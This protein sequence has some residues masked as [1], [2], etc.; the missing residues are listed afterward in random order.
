MKTEGHPITIQQGQLQVPSDPIIPF[1]QGDGVGPDIWKASVRVIE[2]AV[3]KAYGGKRQIHW[4]ELYAGQKAFDRSGKWLPQETI[5]TIEQYLIAL[6][7]PLAIPMGGGIRSLNIVLRQKLDLYA[8]LRPI[9]HISGIPSFL[10]L[11]KPLNL[12]FFQE[13]TEDV[14]V[15]IEARAGSEKSEL[16][17]DF[18]EDEFPEEFVKLRFGSS[19]KVEAY[20]ELLST[21]ASQ[22]VEVGLNIKPTSRQGV[23]RL[24]RSVIQY[25]IRLGKKSIILVHKG[26]ISSAT[27]GVLRDWGYQLAEREFGDLVYTW[28]QF[29]RRTAIESQDAARKEWEA[30]QQQNKI[31]IRDMLYNMAL[32][33]LLS[34]PQECEIMVSLNLTGEYMTEIL[35]EQLG[36]SSLA[37]VGNINYLTGHAVFEVAHGTAF[38]QAGK[39]AFNPSSMILAGSLLLEYIGWQEA[40]ELIQKGVESTLMN[41]QLTY[42]LYRQI[43][44]ATVLRCSE[45]GDAVIQHMD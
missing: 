29:D 31:V 13:K 19:E 44:E 27:E 7:G 39:D 22:Q 16:L 28:G 32:R 41:H 24:I 3:R 42:D 17:L 4:L 40:A 18:L 36:S 35:L 23:E 30:A 5:D 12:M 10:Q 37:P 45:F 11:D 2:A 43:Q 38:S 33:H 14:H 8:C 20:Q 9:Q 26:N 21:D 34:H 6:Q 25:A 1:I 15:G